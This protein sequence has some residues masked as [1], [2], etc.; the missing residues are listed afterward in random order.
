[1]KTRH[2][3]HGDLVDGRL[4]EHFCALCDSFESAEHFQTDHAERDQGKW[5][6]NSLERW[7]RL[8]ESDRDGRYRPESADNILLVCAVEE[9]NRYEA[10]RSGF[11][12]WLEKQVYRN[13]HVGDLAKDVMIDDD[14]PVGIESAIAM[15][16]HLERHG[17]HV[18]E[19]VRDA[20]R[21]F[22]AQTD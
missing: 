5:L 16:R 8:D 20:W 1:M 17:D 11:H 10:S 15:E 4:G 13:D 18:V 19:A 22:R 7:N 21:D 2:Y 3:L 14:F 9:R 6:L 12:R